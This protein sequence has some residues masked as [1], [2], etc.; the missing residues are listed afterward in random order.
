MN[1]LGG[2]PNARLNITV[3]AAGVCL[4][5]VHLATGQIKPIFRSERTVILVE[6]KMKLVMGICKRLIVLHH[7]QGSVMPGD[8]V[9]V[10]V[11]DGFM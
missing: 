5:D 11:M 6:H 10:M 8:W 2:T 7:G 3:K 9:D 4:S 1:W